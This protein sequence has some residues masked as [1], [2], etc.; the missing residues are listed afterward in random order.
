MS[1]QAAAASKPE[2]PEEP[3]EHEGSKLLKE[4]PQNERAAVMRTVMNLTK[5]KEL[6]FHFEIGFKRTAPA[7]ISRAAEVHAPLAEHAQPPLAF[8]AG[9]PRQAAAAQ[10]PD[11]AVA[12]PAGG[13][14]GGS[15]ST[16]SGAAVYVVVKGGSSQSPPGGYPPPP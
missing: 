4:F 7:A 11:A 9:A 1:T 6:F 14:G 15:G 12:L 5:T 16:Q 10:A 3:G 8:P 13:A 2:E